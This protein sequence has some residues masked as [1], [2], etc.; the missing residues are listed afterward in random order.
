VR[1]TGQTGAGLNKQHFGFRA[2]TDARFGSGGWSGESAGGKF[3]RRSPLV[4]NR[5][6]GRSRSF[7]RERKDG[8]WFSLH[9][10]VLI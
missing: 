10:L 3:A 7:E 4:L 6:D 1:Q 2:R 5:G 9:G 8:P